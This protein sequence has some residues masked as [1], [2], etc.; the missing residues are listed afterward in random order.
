MWSYCKDSHLV[1]TG[2]VVP[3]NSISSRGRLLSIG[4]EDFFSLG[5]DEAGEFV[6]LKAFMPWVLR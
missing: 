2:P 6:S 4:F 1:S 3:E 5:P